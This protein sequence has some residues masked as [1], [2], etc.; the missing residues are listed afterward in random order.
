MGGNFV[1][2]NDSHEQHFP[3]DGANWWRIVSLYFAIERDKR[4]ERDACFYSR[5]REDGV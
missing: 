1:Y 2:W 4:S 3:Y 5:S